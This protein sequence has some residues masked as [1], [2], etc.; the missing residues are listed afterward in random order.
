MSSY[1]VR[2]GQRGVLICFVTVGLVCVI[3]IV[4]YLLTMSRSKRII[5]N[6]EGVHYSFYACYS[7]S[8]TVNAY[9]A[10]V[11]AP[12]HLV[13]RRI[14]HLSWASRHE[15]DEEPLLLEQ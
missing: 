4:A 7:E 6:S 8:P 14:R 9:C 10:W 1:S 13:D 12:I 2:R 15:E 11:F 5:G 3:Y